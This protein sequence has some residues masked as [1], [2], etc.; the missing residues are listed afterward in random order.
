[1]HK[2][3]FLISFGVWLIILPFFGIPGTWKD[4]LISLSGIFLVLIFSWPTIST[5]LQIKSKLG[6]IQDVVGHDYDKKIDKVK[7]IIEQK[8]KSEPEKEI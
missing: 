7:P 5:K 2:N 4:T 3:N 1:M 8:P 6:K